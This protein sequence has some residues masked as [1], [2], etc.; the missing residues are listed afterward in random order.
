VWSTQD[1][2]ALLRLEGLFLGISTDGLCPANGNIRIE[3]VV[4]KN[5]LGFIMRLCLLGMFLLSSVAAQAQ[6]NLEAWVRRYNA[7][8]SSSRDYGRKIAVDPEGNVVVAGDTDDGFTGADILVIKYSGAGVPLWTNR[9]NGT[10]SG[11][12]RGS[13]L[14]VDHTG[15][16]F[17]TGCSIDL[18]G[19]SNFVTLAY[20]PGGVPLWTNRYDEPMNG[21]DASRAVAA[22]DNGN[23]FVTG[24]S[25]GREVGGQRARDSVTIAYSGAGVPLWTNRSPNEAYA[26][27]VDW[28]GNVFVTR[29]GFSTI[30]YSGAGIPLWTNIY[31]VPGAM[32]SPSAIAVDS[33]G[34]VVV[35]GSTYGVGSFYDDHYTT[36]AYSPLGVALWTNL[37]DGPGIQDRATALA[38]DHNGNVFVTGY[39]EDVTSSGLN[40][41]FATIAYSGTGVPLWTNRYAGSDGFDRPYA[42][43]VD[44][45]GNV[46]VTGGSGGSYLTIAYSGAG[47]A[48]WT[49]R[50][51]ATEAYAL[52][53]DGSGN[54]F[55]TG[56]DY[57]TIAYSGAGE[58]LW[59]NRFDEPFNSNDEASAVAV[60]QRSGNVLVTGSSSSSST[61]PFSSSSSDFVTIA[62]SDAGLPLWTNRYNG[63]EN[64]GDAATAIAVGSDGNVFVTGSSADGKGYGDYATIAYSASGVGLWTNRYDSF[65][66]SLDTPRAVAVARNGDV[67]VTG[68]SGGDY[69]TVAYSDLG[70]ALWTNRYDG[71]LNSSDEAAAVAVSQSSGVVFVTGVSSS[72]FVTIAYSQAGFALWTNRYS[73]SG[74]AYAIAVDDRGHVFVT[75]SDV[76]IA[77]SEAGTLLWTNRY[78][79]GGARAIAVDRNG[80]VFV[81]GYSRGIGGGFAFDYLTI[82]YS[83]AG[84]ALWT[85]RYNG[86]GNTSH[87][88]YAVA[89]DKSGNVFVTGSTDVNISPADYTTIAYS[90]GGTPL[91]TNVYNG[92]ANGPDRPGLSSSLWPS[93]CLAIGPHD[94]VYVTGRSDGHYGDSMIYDYTTIKYVWRPH[95]EIQPLTAGSSAVNLTL[96]GPQSSSWSIQRALTATGPWTNMGVSLIGT[97][98]RGNFHDANPPGSGAFYRTAQP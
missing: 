13:G 7:G 22:D 18:I 86:T 58:V 46:F 33:A 17:V 42:I 70:T 69:A 12:D 24:F 44:K 27:A 49:N 75:G 62:Y 65:T 29:R 11:D 14:A 74:R 66:N 3:S 54:V 90:P 2:R 73:S 77:Y 41:D 87:Q 45:S 28:S 51:G 72:V 37:Y 21:Q 57:A 48:L 93:K 67:I 6:S 84:A 76:T 59:T 19:G 43:A 55:V 79:G 92:P 52:A 60:D 95:L 39:S 36:I 4:M 35:T 56:Y 26:L 10:A 34:N 78:D 40:V 71:P 61:G 80:N 68:S 88:A 94:E 64:R 83:G 82:A 8:D 98:G 25:S 91:W 5:H 20:S 53:V 16:V 38:V 97:N 89:V 50:Y 63:P 32:D 1:D 31:D 96:S 81:T 85:N 47:A 23:V 30:A 9:Y 15:N